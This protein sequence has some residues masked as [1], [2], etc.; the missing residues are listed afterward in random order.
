MWWA[1]PLGLIWANRRTEKYRGE[2]IGPPNIPT[3]QL[4]SFLNV[5]LIMFLQWDIAGV[6]RVPRDDKSPS[7]LI[8]SPASPHTSHLTPTRLVLAFNT[9][10]HHLMRGGREKGGG[11][12]EEGGNLRYLVYPNL[13]WPGLTDDLINQQPSENSCGFKAKPG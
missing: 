10:K 7:G 2:N 6:G 9:C 8:T 1:V 12:R 3:V 11:R 4:L 13:A 5:N